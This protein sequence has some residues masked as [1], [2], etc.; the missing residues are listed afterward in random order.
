MARVVLSF[1]RRTHIVKKGEKSRTAGKGRD[2]SGEVQLISFYQ[3]VSHAIQADFQRPAGLLL[4]GRP[5]NLIAHPLDPHVQLAYGGSGVL[6]PALQGEPQ[7]VRLAVPELDGRKNRLQN[8]NVN[9]MLY[10]A[11]CQ[12]NLQP[13]IYSVQL[14]C[15]YVS[16][17]DCLQMRA[18]Q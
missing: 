7:V 18:R 15:N 3:G 5:G 2:L 14:P 4:V 12:Q 8:F 11:A 9:C 1:I 13:S 17:Q 10:T 16:S 6:A